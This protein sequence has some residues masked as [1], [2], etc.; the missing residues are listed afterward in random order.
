MNMRQL[1]NKLYSA[2]TEDS[3]DKIVRAYPDIF[4]SENWLPLG[5]NENN[6]GV[7]ENQ[8]SN[9]IAALIEKIT[10]AI[11]AVLMKKCLESGIDPKSDSAPRSMEEAKVKFFADHRD[12]DLSQ[13][14]SR[15]AENIQIIADGP[16]FNTSLTI[17]DNGEGQH[18]PLFCHY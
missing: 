1:F 2:D 11:D 12:W 15:Q 14:R 10:N 13:T 6:F 17:Y 7:I 8:Q 9:P 16:R 4:K 3:V 5:K 18:P